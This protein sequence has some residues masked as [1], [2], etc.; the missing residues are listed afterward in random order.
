MP[1][2]QG[3]PARRLQPD[4]IQFLA[5]LAQW[6]GR[7]LSRRA[8]AV[9]HPGLSSIAGADEMD[10]VAHDL[11]LLELD[12]PIRLPSITPFETGL[13]P[14]EGR[15]GG[16][17]L[18]C[19]GPG[20]GAVAAGGLPCAGARSRRC[21]CCPA[22]SISDPP[23]RRSFRCAD[24]VARVVSVISAKAEV[25]GRKVALGVP[26]EQPLAELLAAAGRQTAPV[27]LSSAAKVRTLSGGS[28]AAGAKFVKP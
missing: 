4:E 10:R 15:C 13:R 11:A 14:A 9:A 18:L 6:P 23:A 20:R 27:A 3:Q 2:R 28:A 24:G 19:A 22:T 7:G 21:W 26:L 25:D 16:R 12:Q 5:G 1:V 17:G 8:R